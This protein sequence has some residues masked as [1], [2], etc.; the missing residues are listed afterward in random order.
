MFICI[1]AFLIVHPILFL[2]L[3]FYLYYTY[4]NELDFINIYY[5][6]WK[7]HPERDWKS[8]TI[9]FYT[10]HEFWFSLSHHDIMGQYSISFCCP[11]QQK[12]YC[13]NVTYVEFQTPKLLWY[14]VS[15]K[16]ILVILPHKMI[17]SWSIFRAIIFIWSIYFQSDTT[18][19]GD[20]GIL[21][22]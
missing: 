5:I 20:F 16:D 3:W 6:H 18:K 17:Y 19:K 2:Y 1:A 10:K 22:S 12:K 13:R 7:S 14:K 4:I 11:W 21:L 15:K 9:R 8:L